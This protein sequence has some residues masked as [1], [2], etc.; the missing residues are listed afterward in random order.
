VRVYTRVNSGYEYNDYYFY[1]TGT[2][3]KAGITSPAPGGTMTG[4]SATFKWSAGA[5]PIEYQLWVSALGVGKNELY[6]SGAT[7]AHTKTVTG[8]P[9][10]GGKLYV[11]LYSKVGS[12]WLY[13]DYTYTAP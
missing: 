9:I 12:T 13:V 7:T 10:T 3:S 6:N 4:T 11:R 5:G 2:P 8:L 1:A